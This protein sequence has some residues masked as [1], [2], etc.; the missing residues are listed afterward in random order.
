[1]ATLEDLVVRVGADVDDAEDAVGGLSGAIDRHFAAITA[2]GVAAG[3]GLEAFAR[4]MAPLNEANS[5]LAAMTGESE[6]AMRDLALETS[7]VGFPL[8]E[9][10]EL[11]ETGSQRGLEG[12]DALQRYANFWDMVGDATGE[13]ATALGQAGTALAAVGIEAGNEAEAVNALGFITENTTGSVGDFLSFLERTGPELR[14]M[15]VD[16]NAAAAIL[17]VMEQELGMTGRTARSE[18][19]SAVAE[20]EGDMSKLLDILGIS[21]TQFASFRGQVD[22]T[23]GVLERNAAINDESF[24]PLQRL[25]H[26]AE[27]LMFNYGGLADA[28]GAVAI[29]MMAIGPLASGASMAI[30]GV[31][32]AATA[33]HLGS[34]VAWLGSMGRAAVVAGTNMARAAGMF[35]A[36]AARMAASMAVTAARVVAMWVLMAIQSLIQAARMAIAWLIA[37]GPIGLVIAAVV[38]IVALI[39]LNW[40]KVVAFLVAA[41]EFIKAAFQAAIDFIVGLVTAWIKLYI[42]IWTG[43]WSIVR[44]AVTAAWNF[45]V[46]RIEKAVDNIR[47]WIDRIVGFVR[48]LPGRITSAASGMWDGIKNAFRAAVNWLI[49]KWNGL[50]F[51]VPSVSFLGMTVGGFTLSTPNIP[52]LAKGGIV[53][54]PTLAMLGEGGHDEA[55]IPL[56]RGM[57]GMG[58]GRGIGADDLRLPGTGLDRL[59]LVW[60]QQLLRDNNL[61]LVG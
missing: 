3:A 33:M 51:S 16:V 15:G 55:V 19:R 38:A 57:R 43:L 28:A 36:N 46:G 23:S 34:A 58:G 32:A 17:G 27:E 53:T 9:V 30:R 61:Q 35:I 42:A 7:N 29:P 18:F 13:S 10:Q 21:E 52:M 45:I 39:I 60:L 2:A 26:Q 59:A 1:M 22:Q 31:S 12:A 40:E 20:S 6:Q 14:S 47:G 37:M 41:W 48:G 54:G 56:P 44:N 4:N 5:R 49:G 8:A 24:T 50:S 11:M 25:T